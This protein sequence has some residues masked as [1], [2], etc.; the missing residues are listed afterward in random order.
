MYITPRLIV[1]MAVVSFV[2]SAIIGALA[3]T[4]LGV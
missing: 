4:L 3:L 1:I 2:V